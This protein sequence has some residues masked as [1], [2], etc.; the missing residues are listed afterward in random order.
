[1]QVTDF[2]CDGIFKFVPRW[3]KCIDVLGD[4]VGKNDTSVK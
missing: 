2:H 4:L 3:D 1:M